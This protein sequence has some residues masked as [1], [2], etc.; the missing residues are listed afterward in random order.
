MVNRRQPREKVTA[1]VPLCVKRDLWQ[2]KRIVEGMGA[3]ICDF[4]PQPITFVLRRV[5]RNR[6][7]LG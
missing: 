3:A 4:S 7:R 6:A 1:E 5:S 2:G